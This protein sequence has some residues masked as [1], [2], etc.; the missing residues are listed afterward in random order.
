VSQHP[1]GTKNYWT[2]TPTWI[3]ISQA[4]RTT[5]NMARK[6]TENEAKNP[7]NGDHKRKHESTRGSRRAATKSK[8]FEP[9]TENEPLKTDHLVLWWNLRM[10][11]MSCQK[12]CQ[13]TTSA[14][15]SEE[16]LLLRRQPNLLRSQAAKGRSF[17]VRVSALDLLLELRSSS[18]D[19]SPELLAKPH[20]PTS[21][22]I[23]TPCCS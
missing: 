23:L 5:R 17:G 8:Y 12:Y 15:R 19:R 1:Q 13:K 11:L 16:H 6:S 10:T 18:R 4:K 9:D 20:T 2:L 21:L 14:Q 3:S 22:S 7:S